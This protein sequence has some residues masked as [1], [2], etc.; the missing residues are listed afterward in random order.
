MEIVNRDTIID[1]LIEADYPGVLQM[2]QKYLIKESKDEF[3]YLAAVDA[4]LGLE[5]YHGA[6]H[7]IQEAE[8]AGLATEDMLLRKGEALLMLDE[9]QEALDIAEDLL[10]S[11]N[12]EQEI[13]VLFLKGRAELA[14]G[15]ASEAALTFE[16]ILL[17]KED[18]ETRMLLAFAYN[19]LDKLDRMQEN[20]D[21]I[22]QDPEF[23]N[24][25][26]E[27][28]A[29][30][31][32]IDLYHENLCKAN[33][34]EEGCYYWM[35]Y[36]YFTNKQPVQAADCLSKAGHLSGDEEMLQ[37]AGCLY[38]S[39]GHIEEGRKILKQLETHPYHESCL[40]PSQYVRNRLHLLAELDYTSAWYEKHF[41]KVVDSCRQ[42]PRAMQQA[43]VCALDMN[44]LDI[45]ETLL[46]NTKFPPEEKQMTQL[47]TARLLLLQKDHAKAYRILKQNR[48][49]DRMWKKYLAVAAYNLTKDEEAASL[50][51]E[52]M[53][54]GDIAIMAILL[55][56]H[57]NMPDRIVGIV[58]QMLEALESG[59]DV[60]NVSDYLD[61]LASVQLA[62]LV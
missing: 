45:A 35:Y 3:Y 13:E 38:A 9:Y 58:K 22:I 54:D 25:I 19:E 30:R 11:D 21:M 5:D 55:Y 28:L 18:P 8:E 46:K 12:N 7:L 4:H 1:H 40:E 51:D 42:D 36:F 14:L 2:L 47:L 15:Q 6:L 33:L 48:H 49:P 17:E 44:R 57:H 34:L 27:M 61:F 62:G 41:Y 32:D 26:F 10:M 31:D 37:E 29:Q 16:D 43:I 60:E 53:P 59:Q 23:E 24:R 39:V 20:L 52:L 50:I 56:M